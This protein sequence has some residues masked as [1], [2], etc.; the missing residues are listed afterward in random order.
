MG[1][2]SRGATKEKCLA[3]YLWR[4]R[5]GRQTHAAD[6]FEIRDAPGYRG[7]D[8]LERLA[9]ASIRYVAEYVP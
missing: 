4:R 5:D 9:V 2:S 7:C 3:D 8:W 1:A 6:G